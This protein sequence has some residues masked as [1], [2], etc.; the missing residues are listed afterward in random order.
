MYLQH[1]FFCSII[2]LLFIFSI[3]CFAE[4]SGSGFSFSLDLGLGVESFNEDTNDDGMDD[5]MVTYQ[6]LVL[7]PD[8]GFGKF[9]IGFELLF[10]YQFVDS[11]L[12]I[13]EED[14]VPQDPTFLNILELYLSKFRYLRYG[15][16]G[17]PLYV[18]FGSIDDGT[19]GNGFIMGYYSNTLFLPEKRI[20]GLGFDVDG[21]L[22]DFPLIGMETFVGNIVNWNVLGAR[23]YFRPLVFFDIPI[24]NVMEVGGEV[25]ADI[26]PDA[27][28]E[29]ALP[30][31]VLDE[32]EDA[33]VVFYDLDVRVPILSNDILTLAVF[34]DAG[35]YKF[36][37]AGGM[38]GFGGTLIKFITYG[39]QARFIGEGFIPN[40]F[41][42][43]YDLF[44]LGYYINIERM[45]GASPPPGYVGY[46]FTLGT[47]IEGLFTLQFTLD[48]PFGVVESGNE[49]NPANYPHLRGTFNLAENVIPGIPGLSVDAV[50]DKSMLRTFG[51][52]IDP[53]AAFIQAKV[54][55]KIAPAV[56][57]FL[58]QLTY[59]AEDEWEI[60]SGLETTISF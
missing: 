41:N 25:V 53:E 40:Y 58:Y 42:G 34:G 52:L 3:H 43:T 33:Q 27:Y 21:A 5:E 57:S 56:I 23:L 54:N 17:D 26:N 28:Y 1:K 30:D 32:F 18:K 8:F 11:V 38:L 29:D 45:E 59:S 24:L 15:Y 48:G 31:E 19:I 22:F 16:K 39:A 37:S 47:G 60:T 46:L 35:T 44:K 12:T 10:H 6:K 36:E 51:D 49:D 9:G 2:L 55:Y 7:A 50:Y 4:E 20:F 13:R 14:W